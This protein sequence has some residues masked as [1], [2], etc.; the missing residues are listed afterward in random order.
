MNITVIYFSDRGK[1]LGEKI[2]NSLCKKKEFSIDVKKCEKGK[3]HNLV[4]SNMNKEAIIFVSSCG[5]AVRAV[6]PF[7]KSKFS[8]PAI[9]SLDE[10]GKFV[11]SLLSGHY[12]RA[13]YLAR[14][15]ARI[16]NAV[17]VITTATDV[18]NIF[19][20]DDFAGKYSMKILFSENIKKIAYKMIDGK[21]IKLLSDVEIKGDIPQGIIYTLSPID[22]DLIISNKK[23]SEDMKTTQLIPK[24]LVLGIGCKKNTSYEAIDDAINSFL[25]QNHFRKEA[26]LFLSSIDLKEKEKG[27][28]SF[29]EEN[30]IP[31]VTYNSETLIEVSGVISNSEFVK[32]NTG[33]NCVCESAALRA[34]EKGTLLI[35]KT[36]INHITLAISE[37]TAKTF[38]WRE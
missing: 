38:N 5:I 22:A 9:I 32:Q 8:D 24:N 21:N 3:L 2:S 29:S 18:H 20:F 14:N 1:V 36:V 30:K 12:G 6:A 17:P 16:I 13:N 10:K 26:L 33:I 19:A 15:I 31:F 23:Y 11:V 27:I 25:N 35:K 37:D 7:V 4:V 34:C 28:I